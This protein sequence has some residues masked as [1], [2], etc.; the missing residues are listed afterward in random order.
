L[1]LDLGHRSP[2]FNQDR[3]NVS[4][5]LKWKSPTPALRYLVY[6]KVNDADYILYRTT[7]NGEEIFVDKDIPINNMYSYQIQAIYEKGIRSALS[8]ELMVKF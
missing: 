6:R 4:I 1:K 7:D 3:D 5:T 8:E 2:I